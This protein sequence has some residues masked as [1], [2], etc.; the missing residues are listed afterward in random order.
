MRNVLVWWREVVNAP[1]P[2]KKNS[3]MRLQFA[4]CKHSRYQLCNVKRRTHEEPADSAKRQYFAA[5][6]VQPLSLIQNRDC[7]SGPY[8]HGLVLAGEIERGQACHKSY[9]T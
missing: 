7:A 2:V 4:V 5:V 3:Q 9:P 8:V 1:G 6:Q